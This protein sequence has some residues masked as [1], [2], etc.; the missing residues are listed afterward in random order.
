MKVLLKLVL[1]A[2]SVLVVPGVVHAA[3]RGTLQDAVAMVQKAKAYIKANGNER[4]YAEISNPRGQFVKG[5][6]YIYVY[7]QNLKNLAHGGNQRLI[8]KD[9]AD[10]KD[11]DGNY[12]NRGL[13]EA[14]RKGGGTYQF[15]FLNP[16][17]HEI[18]EKTGYSEMVGDVMVGS[19]AYR[20]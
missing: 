2:F 11:S 20:K 17:T 8:G 19:G 10:M 15:K 9:L 3:E 18:E 6:I 16:A 1:F 13:L 14:A 5:D 4:A 12:F 7:D